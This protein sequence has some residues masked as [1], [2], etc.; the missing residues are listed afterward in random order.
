M[1]EI[2]FRAWDREI[3][4]FIPIME[5]IEELKHAKF[6]V[7]GNEIVTN[8]WNI[9]NLAVLLKSKNIEITQCT[10]L[11]DIN[12]L[13]VYEGDILEI[14]DDELYFE[15][16]FDKSDLRYCATELV[17]KTNYDLSDFIVANDNRENV[18]NGFV[19]GNIYENKNFL[20]EE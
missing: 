18:I 10:G 9:S 1:R 20:E 13:E 16:N 14:P 15:V 17:L 12:G 6:R 3:K 11:K 2:K 5:W 7:L 4:C 19:V 8:G